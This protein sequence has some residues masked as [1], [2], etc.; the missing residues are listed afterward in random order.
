MPGKQFLS[1]GT[2]GVILIF[3]SLTKM[4][5]IGA[6]DFFLQRM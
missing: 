1:S 6:T 4:E 2:S 3:L 5:K